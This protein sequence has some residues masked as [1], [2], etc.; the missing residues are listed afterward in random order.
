MHPFIETVSICGG[1]AVA[2]VSAII[3]LTLFFRGIAW[4]SSAGAKPD[5]LAVRGVLKKDT[6]ATV[7]LAGGKVFERVRFVGFTNTESMKTRLPFELNG[8]VILEDEEQTRFLIRA[9]DIKMIVVPTE[10]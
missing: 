10:S 6:L 1:I 4:L 8:M 9:R 3:V 5:T 7:H 2:L